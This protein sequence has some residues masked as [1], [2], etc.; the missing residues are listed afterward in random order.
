MAKIKRSWAILAGF[1]VIVLIGFFI[2][3]H[4]L[5][6]D[7]YRGRIE[8]AISDSLG[9]QATLGHLDFSLL[10]GSLVAE[11]PSIADDPAFSNQPFLTAKSVH[12]GVEV[13]PLIFH[14]ELHITSFT[15]D[16]PKITLLR[17]QNGTWNYSSIGGEGK[18][19]AP[20]AETNNLVPN[21]TVGK[22]NIKGGTVTVGSVPQQ[23][24]PHVYSDVNVS[25]Q[26]FS[27]AGQFPF[28]VDA[29]LPAGGSLDI[30]GNAGP[31]NQHDASLT[32]MTAQV[33]L[34]HAD[35]VAA[36]FV[37][38]SQGISGIADL[39]T[40][41]VSNG[42]TAQ[43]DGKLHL[44][45]LKLAKNG[46]SSAQPVDVQFTVNQDLQALSGKI[47]KATLQIGKSITLAVAGTYQ[48]RGNTITTQINVNGQNMP[49]DELVA[50]LPSLGVQLPSGSR[51]QGGTLTTN[52]NISGPTTAPVIAGP[53]RIANTQL[54]GF[55]LGKK[56]ASIQSLTGAKTGSNTTIQALST[57]LHYGPDGTRTDNLAA[58]V[59]GLGSAS[60]G[61][62]I[63]PTNALN[64]RLL[65]KLNTSSGVGGLA[66]QALGMIP[67]A[68]GSAVTQTT[69][70]GIPLTIGGTTSN[71][72]FTPDVSKMVVGAPQQKGVQSNPLG[73]ALSGLIPR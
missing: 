12:I 42:Q 36:G 5:D 38:P 4:L 25:V 41:V 53:V 29:K 44:T 10:S 65:V 8:T 18:R 64:Y 15:I 2:I 26:N 59:A 33:S 1:V 55:D 45:Q 13:A 51:L 35:L 69:K 6:A 66:T 72:T 56:L 48:T 62:S 49:I 57:D 19:K 37:E 73:K 60:G 17:G 61:G 70:N 34:K 71:P 47:E 43:A 14:R 58:V 54:A 7:T 28:A 11:A 3:Q 68:F 50:F 32:P 16:Q 24:S 20:T 9:R 63:S 27:F 22:I 40:K 39:D 23:V 67:G 21:L 30:K 46:S 52:L 31:I